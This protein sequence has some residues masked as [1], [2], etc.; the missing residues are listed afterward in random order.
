MINHHK[1]IALD[2]Y[3]QKELDTDPK[4]IQQI[5]F[6]EQLKKIEGVNADRTQSMFVL[7]V[8]K[9]IKETKLKFLHFYNEVKQPYKG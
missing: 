7:T 5:E 3:K 9:K 8:L 6:V 4:V 1:L 2:Y